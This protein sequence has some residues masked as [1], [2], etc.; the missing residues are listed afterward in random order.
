MIEQMNDDDVERVARAIAM[1]RTPAYADD[2]IWA[3]DI[4]W[5]RRSINPASSFNLARAALSAMPPR[6]LPPNII[7]MPRDIGE[8]RAMVLIGENMMRAAGEI[9][10]PEC[11]LLREALAY[12]HQLEDCVAEFLDAYTA[13]NND[14][15]DEVSMNDAEHGM[16]LAMRAFRDARAALKGTKE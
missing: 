2:K 11:E 14:E 9:K 10:E 16:T 4:E 7:P 3:E 15:L 1:H 8:A 6:E 12:A 5:Q 13:F